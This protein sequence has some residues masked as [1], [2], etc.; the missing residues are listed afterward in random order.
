MRGARR[1]TSPTTCIQEQRGSG[2][3]YRRDDAAEVPRLRARRAAT[4]RSPSSARATARPP[5]RSAT[6]RR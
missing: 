3:E 6:A 4:S 1:P 5:R 2:D